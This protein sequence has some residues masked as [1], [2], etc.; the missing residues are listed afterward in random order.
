MENINVNSITVEEDHKCSD[1]FI[2]GSHFSQN[3]IKAIF[4][5][6][7]LNR[8]YKCLS[9]LEPG[10]II[11]IGCFVGNFVR[12]VQENFPDSEVIGIDYCRDHINAAK[13]LYPNIKHCFKEMSVYDLNFPENSIDCISFQETIEHIDNVVPAI[14]K[15]NKILKPGGS[16]IVSTPHAY[17]YK[18]FIVFTCYEIKRFFAK[19]FLKKTMPLEIESYHGA[20]WMRHIYCWTPNT[21]MTLLETN[22]FSYVDHTY[23]YGSTYHEKLPHMMRVINWMEKYILKL[24][25]IF[26]PQIILKVRKERDSKKEYL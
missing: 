23:G 14:R 19:K 12:A 24:F 26:S 15:I 6:K 22:G 25:P 5:Q 17:Y 21:L 18:H 9:L 1:F 8:E 20:E 11:D 3:Q 10:K 16:L 2:C 13:Y 4:F 7:L